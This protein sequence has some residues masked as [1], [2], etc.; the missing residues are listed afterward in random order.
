MVAKNV[1]SK[2]TFLPS[3]FQVSDSIE[4]VHHMPHEDKILAVEFW[5]DISERLQ[6]VVNAY[7][8][9]FSPR[10]AENANRAFEEALSPK[11]S[12]KCLL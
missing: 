6:D 11:V 4:L 12:L 1:F 7:V 10:D 5:N 9:S 8:K 2:K 3:S